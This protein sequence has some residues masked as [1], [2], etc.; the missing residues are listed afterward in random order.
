VEVDGEHWVSWVVV[1]EQKSWE[2]EELVVMLFTILLRY[3]KLEVQELLELDSRE[4]SGTQ[5]CIYY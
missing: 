5:K 1:G 4:G 2:E 3:S